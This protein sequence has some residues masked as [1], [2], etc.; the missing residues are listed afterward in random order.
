MPEEEA[1]KREA[2][3]EQDL[4]KGIV[5]WQGQNDPENP[6]FEYFRS[7]QDSYC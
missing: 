7:R 3:P 6:R 4:D 5:G 2:Y 1:H